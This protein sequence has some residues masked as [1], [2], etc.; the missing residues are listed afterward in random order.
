VN[1]DIPT[2]SENDD[3]DYSGTS[4]S[5]RRNLKVPLEM[6]GMR[7]DAGL[8]ALLPEFSRSRL[9]SW[10]REGLLIVDKGICKDTK[11][12]LMGG[13]DLT[14]ESEPDPAILPDEPED[15]P[16]DVVF[17]DEHILVINKPAGLVVHPG[18]GNRTGTLL[19]AL[20][21][22]DAQLAEIPR[23]GIVH[24]LDKDTSGL[25]VVAKT[26]IA[27][28]DLVRQLQARTV[29]RHYAAVVMGMPPVSGTVDDPV[30]RHPTQRTRMTV[31]AGGKEAR[32]HFRVVERLQGATW[33]ECVLDT[34]RTHQIRVHMAHLRYPLVGD[35]VY[36]GRNRLPPPAGDFPRQALQ[37]YKLGLIHP[38]TRREMFWEVPLADD[39]QALIQMLRS[40]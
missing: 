10:V 31:M 39:L 23:A 8:A 34:G 21:A 28:T 40:A 16:L 26:L 6:A 27:Q 3:D 11:Y 1:I 25:M 35:P 19:N 4:A 37:A 29:K 5:N 12:R 38:E 14:L 17:E 30:D 7:L 22:H 32:T 33:L 18:N 9:Q 13:E 36:A 20:L 24:R 15:I 2:P